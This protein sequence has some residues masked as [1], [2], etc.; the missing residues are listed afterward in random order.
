MSRLSKSDHKLISKI[1]TR[2]IKMKLNENLV[3][4]I[5]DITVCH[6]NS[7]LRL[8]ELLGANDINFTHDIVGINKHLNRKTGKLRNHFTPRYSHSTLLHL[9]CSFNEDKSLSID[10]AFL[11]KE[12]AQKEADKCDTG[13]LY[14]IAIEDINDFTI[15]PRI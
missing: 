15:I 8:D 9:V 2:A 10:N 7:P 12:K 14:S 13:H 3:S 5:M 1:A 6:F 4:V 11:S